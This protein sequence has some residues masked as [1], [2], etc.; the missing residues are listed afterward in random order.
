M[1]FLI[2]TTVVFRKSLV[3]SDNYASLSASPNNPLQQ[4][5][6][7]IEIKSTNRSTS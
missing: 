3:I 2:F 5:V 4:Y 7:N 1:K 6:I